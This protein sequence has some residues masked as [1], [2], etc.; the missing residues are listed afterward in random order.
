MEYT[1]DVIDSMPEPIYHQLIADYPEWNI[2]Q[3]ADYYVANRD[4]LVKEMYLE[5]EYLFELEEYLSNQN[6]N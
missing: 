4:S 1:C 3:L 5:Q 6:N 2:D